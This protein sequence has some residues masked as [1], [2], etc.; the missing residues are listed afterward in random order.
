MTNE[1]EIVN[2]WL[3]MADSHYL[4]GRL[5]FMTGLYHVALHNSATSI[6][7]YLKCADLLFN[8]GV[9][10]KGH[11]LKQRFNDFKIVL[12]PTLDTFIAELEDSYRNKYPDAW[13]GDVMWKDRLFELDTLVY[14]F[15]NYI[16]DRLSDFRGAMDLL[17]IARD[18]GHFDDSISPKFGTLNLK[19]VFYRSNNRAT[20]FKFLNS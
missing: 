9:L 2:K 4:S 6:E 1:I 19:D 12:P 18:Y 14:Q 17:R 16:V 15:R 5:L 10:R 7:L 20:S 13:S 8:K 3:F 11:D